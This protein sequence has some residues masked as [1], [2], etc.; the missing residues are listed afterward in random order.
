MPSSPNHKSAACA[1]GNEAWKCSFKK[2]RIT[3]PTRIT[4]TLSRYDAVRRQY[5]PS[6]WDSSTMN[7]LFTT[8]CNISCFMRIMKWKRT[9]QNAW[10]MMVHIR[11]HFA[12]IWKQDALFLLFFQNVFLLLILMSAPSVTKGLISRNPLI[13]SKNFWKIKRVL[14]NSD[15]RM[16]FSYSPGCLGK[17]VKSDRFFISVKNNKSNSCKFV[18][19]PSFYRS[20]N[21]ASRLYANTTVLKFR[22]ATVSK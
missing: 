6:I 12:E 13:G 14:W 16:L 22:S 18:L 4:L 17:L 3:H 8:K 21:N 19:L 2:L 11:K 20:V 5:A 15:T 1:R 7:L 10:E 9:M